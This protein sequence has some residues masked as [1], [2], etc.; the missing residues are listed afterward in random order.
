LTGHA[1]LDRIPQILR[2][3][4]LMLAGIGETLMDRLAKV[5][6]IVEDVEKRP[7][8]EHDSAAG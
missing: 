3:D 7:A 2:N 8:G 1:V 4:G 5:D 6:A